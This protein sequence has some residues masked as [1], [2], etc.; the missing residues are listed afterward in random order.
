MKDA[1]A[2]GVVLERFYDARHKVDW[3]GLKALSTHVMIE[4]TVLA[5]ICRQLAQHHLIEWKPLLGLGE[6]IDGMGRITAH[7][8]DVVEDTAAPPITVTLHDHSISISG[9]SN[10]QI[11]DANQQ[12]VRVEIGKLARI[13]DNMNAPEAEKKHAKGLVEKITNN[14]L[15][16]AAFGTILGKALS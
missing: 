16:V 11:G 10:V 5:N 3:L 1:E 13:I 12:T 8:I 6:V 4:Y 7:G 2:R 9:S 15:V 14:P